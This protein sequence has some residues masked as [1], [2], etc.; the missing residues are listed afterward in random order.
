MA[1]V[2]STDL[3]DIQNDVL[4]TVL[5]NNSKISKI[6]SL[7]TT[8]KS[9]IKAINELNGLLG[10]AVDQAQ[11][12]TQNAQEASAAIKTT[13]NEIQQSM[14]NVVK[15]VVVKE[16]AFGERV[17]LCDD[18][19]DCHNDGQTIFPLNHKPVRDGD[20]LFYV[21]GVKYPKDDYRY[22]AKANNITWLNAV[23]NEAHPHAFDIKKTDSVSAVYMVE[24]ISHNDEVVAG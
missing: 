18:E 13:K 21:N 22:D 16:A 20:I 3:N 23:R 10:A 4:T 5:T 6:N 2:K 9:I 14:Q 12:A 11:T 1:Y 8:A 19:L 7:R 24:Q 15:E 17:Q